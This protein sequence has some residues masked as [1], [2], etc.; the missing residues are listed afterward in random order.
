MSASL[1][2]APPQ[3][4]S[5]ARRQTPLSWPPTSSFDF[6]VLETTGGF[7]IT[8]LAA[9]AMCPAPCQVRP[10]VETLMEGLFWAGLWVQHEQGKQGSRPHVFVVL[11][12]HCLI[13]RF[14]F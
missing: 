2:L 8:L 6:S 12:L 1:E 9:P 14:C 3:P 10:A 4:P 5:V 11:Y 13:I 7:E